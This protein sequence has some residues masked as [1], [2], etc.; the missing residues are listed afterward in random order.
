MFHEGGGKRRR[1]R[2]TFSARGSF[3]GKGS[4]Y[5]RR[6]RTLR[7]GM[8][9]RGFVHVAKTPESNSASHG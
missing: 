2:C 5:S 3:F 4:A 8:L 6:V 7:L 1:R 9:Y